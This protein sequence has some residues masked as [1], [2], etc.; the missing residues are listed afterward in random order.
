MSDT[1]RNSPDLADLDRR[2]LFHP[3]TALADHERTGPPTVIVKGEGVWLEDSAGN[4]YLNSMAG[5][6]CVNVGYG[7]RE[8]AE[9]IHDQALTLSYCHAF[10]SMSA[11]VPI[12]LA[13][14]LVGMAPV[15]M[16]KI[17]FGNSG[18]DAND[19]QVKLVWY[20]N[21]AR[22]LPNKKKII[23]RRRGYHG[24]TLA[25]AGMTGLPGLHAGFDL[26]LPFVKHTTAPHRL[27]EGQGLSDAQFIE[28]AGR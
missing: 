8:I 10:S 18:S 17:F 4:R 26:P 27:W 9:A 7:R 16:S 14:K 15:P 24:V 21:N 25:S 2:F 1:L 6:W 19:T 23:S 20:Y 28:Q 3:F 5:L 11:D 12:L 13:E 22:G